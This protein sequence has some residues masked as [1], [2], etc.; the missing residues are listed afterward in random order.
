MADE[1]IRLSARI[2][3]RGCGWKGVDDRVEVR[4]YDPDGTRPMMA[5]RSRTVDDIDCGGCGAVLDLWVER[6]WHGD[7]DERARRA[8]RK[9]VVTVYGRP[10]P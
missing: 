6:R 1:L 3:C 8:R 9:G 10:R 4:V 5:V 7:G 2:V